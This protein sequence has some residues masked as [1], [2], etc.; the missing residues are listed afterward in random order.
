[1]TRLYGINKGEAVE[2]VERGVTS[3]RDLDDGTLAA[4]KGPP[5]MKREAVLPPRLH[6]RTAE[7][8][9]RLVVAP[10]LEAALGALRAPVVHLDFETV[11]FALPRFPGTHPWTQV[12]VQV[13]AHVEEPDGVK[14]HEFIAD[15][16]D[17]PRPAMIDAVVRA[18]RG[19]GTVLAWHVQFERG[20][21]EDLAVAFPARAAELEDVRRRLED[22]LPIVRAHVYHPDFAGSF[23]LK[24]VLPALVP[25]LGYDDLAI[26]N[27]G[28]AMAALA[29]LM[30]EAEM[31]PEERARLRRDLLAYC[32]RDTWAM[33]RLLARLR[34]LARA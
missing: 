29:R 15:G 13:S 6:Q 10:G 19:G 25:G 17:D 9:G 14:H 11:H 31:A 5:G 7:E 34:E 16:P 8:T 27:G 33:V 30:T 18:C 1:V 26:R 32:E 24:A 3:I 12:P 4:L 2:L 28:A 21:L 22:L 20:R 23:S